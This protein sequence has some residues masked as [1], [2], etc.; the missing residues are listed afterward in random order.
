VPTVDELTDPYANFMLGPSVGPDVCEVCF[1]F[2]Q[3]YPRCYACAQMEQWC[4]AVAPISYSP[5]FGQL[6]NALAAYKRTSGAATLRLQRDLA[7]VLWRY[8]REHEP[9]LSAAAG[10]DGFDL[11]TTVP[12]SDH[13]RDADH[14]LRRIAGEL[15]A[16]TRERYERL[17][18]RSTATVAGRDFS[19]EKYVVRRGL[20]GESVLLIDDTWTTGASVQSAAAALR[21]AGAAR[22]AAVVVGRH[23]RPKFQEN[24][25]RLRAIPRPF[26]WSTCAWHP[27]EPRGG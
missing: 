18:R 7:A 5:Q 24:E 13:A 27:A 16:P 25:R 22:V 14:P 4:S 8:L 1:T 23:V 3:G 15:V 2:T 9:C 17:L 20:A 6:H 26:D 11:V 10:V 19:P 21:G 12:S